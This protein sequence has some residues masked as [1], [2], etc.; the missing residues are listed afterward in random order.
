MDTFFIN[1]RIGKNTRF[2]INILKAITNNP[3]VSGGM[4]N[5]NV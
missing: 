3:D 5:N 2:I 1:V 4:T